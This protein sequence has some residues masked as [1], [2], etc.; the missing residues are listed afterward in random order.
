MYRHIHVYTCTNIHMLM[1]QIYTHTVTHISAMMQP[2]R[3]FQEPIYAGELIGSKL[4]SEEEGRLAQGEE[5][6]IWPHRV[7]A[8]L[9]LPVQGKP[10]REA[11]TITPP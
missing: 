6:G 8:S 11:M 5:C 10:H 2:G 4:E 9:V 1:A 7:Q 3:P